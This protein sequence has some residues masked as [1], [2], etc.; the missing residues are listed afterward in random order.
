MH[1]MAVDAERAEINDG[2]VEPDGRLVRQPHGID[3]ALPVLETL[4]GA[5]VSGDVSADAL[6]TLPG[7]RCRTSLALR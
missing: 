5:A 2:V 3:V 1:Q 6:V 4:T 7:M